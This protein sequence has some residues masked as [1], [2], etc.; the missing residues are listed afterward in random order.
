MNFSKCSKKK[1]DNNFNK[2][3]WSHSQN[4]LSLKTFHFPPAS[5]HYQNILYRV[6]ESTFICINKILINLNLFGCLSSK[7][8]IFIREW[9]QMLCDCMWDIFNYSRNDVWFLPRHHRRLN[10][11]HLFI[12][13]DFV[14]TEKLM[15]MTVKPSRTTFENWL[16][17]F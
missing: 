2:F 12:L 15:R 13:S 17:L 3:Y 16:L 10:F 11:F 14:K 9:L 6:V 8:N 1:V 4:F 5:I 7:E